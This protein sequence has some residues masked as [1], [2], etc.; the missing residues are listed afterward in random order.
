LLNVPVLKKGNKGKMVSYRPITLLVTFSKILET[1][2]F[3]RFNKHLEVNN[4]LVPE[5]FGFRKGVTV[6]KAIFTQADN[7]LTI[8]NQQQL[9][10]GIF[11]DLSKTFDCVNHETLLGKLCFYRIHGGN[12]KWFESYLTNRKQRVNVMSQHHQHKFSS[13]WRAIKCGVP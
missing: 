11:L 6:Q 1:A 2:V 10:G 3:N 12:I 4:I 9:V 8:L 13:N 5:Q 7:I